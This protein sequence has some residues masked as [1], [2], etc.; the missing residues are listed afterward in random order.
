MMFALKNTQHQHI[1]S[2]TSIIPKPI[3]LLSKSIVNPIKV[4]PYQ[5]YTHFF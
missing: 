3:K 4:I 5:P 1:L 2:K